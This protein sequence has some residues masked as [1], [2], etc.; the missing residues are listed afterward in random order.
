MQNLI[1][2]LSALLLIFIISACGFGKKY[3]A[4]SDPYAVQ[5]ARSGKPSCIKTTVPV[6][7]FATQIINRPRSMVGFQPLVPH[8]KLSA[9]AQ[10]H[11]CDMAAS[12]VLSYI[13]SKSVSPLQRLKKR[14]YDARITAESITAGPYDLER[15]LN[16]WN[17]YPRYLENSLQPGFRHFG[18]GHAIAADGETHF[19]V[20]TYAA[21]K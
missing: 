16:D 13:D 12:G 10:K 3:D 7:E 4:T 9:A 19:W 8:Q 5:M 17:T 21:P 1:K 14:K 20:A 2:K 15:V 6:N 11:A 18:I